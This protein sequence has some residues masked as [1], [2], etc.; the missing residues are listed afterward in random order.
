MLD[1]SPDLLSLREVL[2]EEF[3]ALH[4]PLQRST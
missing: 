1:A 3:V 4:G 2:E